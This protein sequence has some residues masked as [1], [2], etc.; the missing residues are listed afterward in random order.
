MKDLPLVF[1]NILNASE[2]RYFLLLLFCVETC[3]FAC[4]SVFCLQ[5]LIQLLFCLNV[6]ADISWT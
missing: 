6:N 4:Y 1:H 3:G 2:I 5:R